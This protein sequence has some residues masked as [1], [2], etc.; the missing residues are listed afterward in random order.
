MPPSIWK[1]STHLSGKSLKNP[2]TSFRAASVWLAALAL[3]CTCLGA[4]TGPS[5]E[6][7]MKTGAQA[8]KNS[9]FAQAEKS[10]KSAVKQ[11]DEQ[12]GDNDPRLANALLGSGDACAGLGHLD[13]AEV[14]YQKALDINTSFSDSEN[15]DTGKVLQRLGH[16]YLEAGQL[17]DAESSFKEAQPILEKCLDDNDPD[18][19]YLYTD[20][21]NLHARQSR[22]GKAE[23]EY[24]NAYTVLEPLVGKHQRQKEVILNA[25]AALYNQTEDLD[26]LARINQKLELLKVQDAKNVTQVLP[27]VNQ[28]QSH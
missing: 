7:E 15:A 20:L 17:S 5:Y 10:F 14:H 8:L 28:G 23:A 9:D 21:G 24:Q 2:S 4:C 27:Y 16:V 12:F 18:L 11:A 3:L 13:E 19:A 6:Q 1:S 25:L 26:K 22:Y